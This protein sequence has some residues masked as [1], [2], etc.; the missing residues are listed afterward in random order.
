MLSKAIDNGGPDLTVQDDLSQYISH[1]L[2]DSSLG[3]AHIGS[4]CFLGPCLII[5]I[6]SGFQVRV[7]IFFNKNRNLFFFL[8]FS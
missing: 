2:K 8:I 3:M 4:G 5:E 6:R 7:F 1:L